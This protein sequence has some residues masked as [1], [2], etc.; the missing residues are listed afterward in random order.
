MVTAEQ[1]APTIVDELVLETRIPRGDQAYALARTG[2]Q[3]LLTALL[4]PERKTERVDRQI[5]DTMIA[6]IDQRIGQKLDAI[7]HHPEFQRLESAWR[8]LRFVVDRTDFRENIA[9]ELYD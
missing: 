3:A 8:G 9:L 6:A 7:L 5:V 1:V 2:V 4:E